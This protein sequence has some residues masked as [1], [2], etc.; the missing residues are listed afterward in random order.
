MI[1]VTFKEVD[2]KYRTL[3]LLQRSDRPRYWSFHCPNCKAFVA[4]LN[5]TDVHAMADFY[6]PQSA[7]NRSVGVRC[8]GAYC[9][10]YYFFVLS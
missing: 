2:H 10:R 5:N 4:E 9:K 1:E 6:N 8:S 3:V 7:D